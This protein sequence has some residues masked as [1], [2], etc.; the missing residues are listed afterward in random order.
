[1]KKNL[2]IILAILLSAGCASKMQYATA[3]QTQG[4]NQA[5]LSVVGAPV[6]AVIQVDGG[7]SVSPFDRNGRATPVPVASGLRKIQVLS[8]QAVLYN[9]TVLVSPGG[10]AQLLVPRS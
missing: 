1:M 6:G 10:T 9:G 4:A 8:G 7:Q 3:A 2:L 5:Y